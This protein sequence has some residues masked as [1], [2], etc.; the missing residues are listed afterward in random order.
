MAQKFN[1][2]A[3]VALTAADLADFMGSFNPAIT[4]TTGRTLAWPADLV[5]NI[6]VN[7]AGAISIGLPNDAGI[8]LG[9]VIRGM[10]IGAGLVSFTGTGIV[11]NAILPATV[12]QYSAFEFRRIANGWVRV[13]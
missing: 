3:N 8:P 5:S 12:D 2:T 9:F 11:G 10:S 1:G 13:A 4:I 6:I 7:S